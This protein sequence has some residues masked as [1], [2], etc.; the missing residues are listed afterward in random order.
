MRVAGVLLELL[1]VVAGSRETLIGGPA[2]PETGLWQ[3]APPDPTLGIER[4]QVILGPGQT[5]LRR[6][7]QPTRAAAL[8]LVN[9][10]ALQEHD[11][12][13]VLGVGVAGGS[14]GQNPSAD[15]LRLKLIHL[16]GL[17]GFSCH[18]VAGFVSKPS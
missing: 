3:A 18:V 6:L 17:I 14:G 16:P 10:C 2:K 13:H 7:L 15:A 4:T 8:I 12:H 5:L 11:A 9:P 1:Q